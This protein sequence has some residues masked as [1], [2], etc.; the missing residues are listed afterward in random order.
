MPSLLAI[1]EYY[2][3]TLEIEAR[4]CSEEKQY[5]DKLKVI[6]NELKEPVPTQ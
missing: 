6:I 4:R 3:A 1:E 2:I 5:F